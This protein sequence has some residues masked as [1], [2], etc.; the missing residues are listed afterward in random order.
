MSP[1]I[2]VVVAVVYGSRR[3]GIAALSGEHL[4]RAEVKCLRRCPD[5]AVR[6]RQHLESYK[7]R[8]GATALCEVIEPDRPGAFEAQGRKLMGEIATAHALTVHTVSRAV[9]RS[10]IA[11]DTRPSNDE[12]GRHVLREHPE[13]GA[14]Y[15]PPENLGR[16]K[17]PTSRE[18]HLY[19]LF[20]AVAGATAAL[21][22]HLS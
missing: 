1:P 17:H 14:R 10:R 11:T 8:F 9:L 20:L 4:Y 22:E 6:F 2:K 19:L 13:L 21:H 5:R 12:I 18:R 3:F 7:R 16:T 15:G